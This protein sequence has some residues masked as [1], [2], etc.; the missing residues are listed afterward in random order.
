MSCSVNSHS[1]NEKP[2]N[3]GLA[4]APTAGGPRPKRLAHQALANSAAGRRIPAGL[5]QARRVLLRTGLALALLLLS[6]AMWNSPS[7]ATAQGGITAFLPL[8]TSPSATGS[9]TSGCRPTIRGQVS[10]D[11]AMERATLDAI[12]DV[13][14]DNGLPPLSRNEKLTQ[15]ARYHANDLADHNMTGHNGS[16]GSDPVDRINGVCYSWMGIGEIAGYG[17]GGDLDRMMDAW[18]DSPGHRGIILSPHYSEFGAG[19][20][21]NSNSDFI[22]YWTVV[23][24]VQPDNAVARPSSLTLEVLIPEMDPGELLVPDPGP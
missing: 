2:Q 16:D 4:S 5:L 23:F 13:R 10:D 24:G 14:A 3:A 11:P 6:S 22:H 18:M 7:P 19:F 15:A 21:I 1:I 9:T 17:F 20:A 12:N 8:V